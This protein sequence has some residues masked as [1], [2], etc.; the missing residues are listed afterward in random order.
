MGR[1]RGRAAWRRARRAAAATPLPWVASPAWGACSCAQRGRRAR[2]RAA[3]ERAA[4]GWRARPAHGRGGRMG[5]CGPTTMLLRL[6]RACWGGEPGT[7]AAETAWRRGGGG[8][9]H[10]RPQGKRGCA[11]LAPAPRLPGSRPGAVLLI[12]V[13][14]AP[15]AAADGAGRPLG[16]PP[17]WRPADEAGGPS[18]RARGGPDAFGSGARLA[19]ASC[20]CVRPCKSASAFTRHMRGS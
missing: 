14:L 9:P 20:G 5:G 19:H 7:R 1:R 17:R 18:A 4:A 11:V 12:P 6:P 3:A 10:A 8:P 15:A 16:S 13:T 2:A